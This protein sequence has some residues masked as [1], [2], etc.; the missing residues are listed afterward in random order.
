MM[1][2]AACVSDIVHHGRP[3]RTAPDPLPPA[4][5]AA[6]RSMAIPRCLAGG[7]VEGEG[8]RGRGKEGGGGERD[9]DGR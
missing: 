5:S 9:L 3:M 1:G 7:C 4:L 8:E 6:S 2:N